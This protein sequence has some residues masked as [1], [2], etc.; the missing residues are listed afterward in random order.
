MSTTNEVPVGTVN[1]SNAVFTI[2]NSAANNEIVVTINGLK[3]KE[4]TDYSLSGTTLTFTVAPFTGALLEVYYVHSTSAAG[5]AVQT[6]SANYTLA[7]TDYVILADTTSGNVT[8]TLPT[9]VGQ[10]GRQFVLK[11][12][13]YNN[14]MV[15]NTTSSQTIDG[16]LSQTITTGSK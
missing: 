4:T 8:L 5:Y 11:K 7:N 1:G 13:S 12:V 9:A 16:D 10:S 15:V 3:Q 14:S 6:K 2:S